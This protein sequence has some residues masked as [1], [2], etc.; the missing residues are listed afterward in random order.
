MALAAFGEAEAGFA[1]ELRMS[2]FSQVSPLDAL[3]RAVCAIV[4][5]EQ[6]RVGAA[7]AAPIDDSR[8]EFAFVKEEGFGLG[9]Q[10]WLCHKLCKMFLGE[11]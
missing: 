7:D 11:G 5:N 10:D 1:W 3:Q 9:S 6:M 2:I 8:I 4:R